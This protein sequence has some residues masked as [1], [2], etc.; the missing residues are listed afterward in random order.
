M[1]D[2]RGAA[3]HPVAVVVVG[4][5]ADLPDLGRMNVAANDAVG[6]AL[7]GRMGDSFLEAA[8]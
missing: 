5:F 1:L 3:L 6:A 8:R 4:D 7:V 2:Q